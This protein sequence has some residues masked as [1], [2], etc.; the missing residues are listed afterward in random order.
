LSHHEDEHFDGH[1][2][3]LIDHEFGTARV[4]PQP[5]EEWFLPSL[6]LLLFE[7]FEEPSRC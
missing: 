1:L 7:W 2:N 6:W 4:L 5:P 3:H